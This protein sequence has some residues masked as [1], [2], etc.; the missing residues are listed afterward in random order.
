M[1][2]FTVGLAQGIAGLPMYSGMGFRLVL[3]VV[4]YVIAV[5]FVYR[6]AMKVKRILQAEFTENSIQMSKT[7]Y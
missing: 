6:H 4:I 7:A 3:F 1:N 5:T 2:P